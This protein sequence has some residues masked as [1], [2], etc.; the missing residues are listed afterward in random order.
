MAV[1]FSN[2]PCCKSS[3][4]AFALAAKDHT[5][6]Q[7]SFE[8]WHC[9]VC[10]ARFTQHIPAEHDISKYYQS[11]NYVSHSDTKKG[12]INSMYHFV[13]K[14][15]LSAKKNLIKKQ[16]RLLTGKVLDVGSGTGAFLN[17]MQ[18]NGWHT[19]GVEPDAPAR[20]KA[21][22][23]YRL[24]LKPSA[25]LFNFLPESF[26]AITMWH[27][28]EHVHDL[29]KYLEQ[30]KKLLKK[31]G[32]IFIAVP[33]YTSYDAKVYQQFWAAYDVPRHLYHFSPV[34]MMQL[35]L[36]H[37]LQ[38]KK[39]KPM[40]YDSFYVSM[41][42]ENYKTGKNNFI[43]ALINGYISNWKALWNKEKCSSVIYIISH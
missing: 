23:L 20:E 9:N 42:S 40:W 15:T 13:R 31:N 8:I 26:D 12:W 7:E 37:G 3:K 38:L 11:E 4:I 14:R 29:D 30:L 1:T 10:T 35:L 32:R 27:V 24:D 41:L 39:I 18:K 5:V 25:E 2:C 21:M 34:S 36:R 33:N 16:I 43:S 17:L 19:E 6:S 22:Y 28:L